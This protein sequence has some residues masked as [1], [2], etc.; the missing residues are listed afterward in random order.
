MFAVGLL[1]AYFI[2]RGEGVWRK[3]LFP[4]VQT[5]R[6]EE[7]EAANEPG[8]IMNRAFKRKLSFPKH[9]CEDLIKISRL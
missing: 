1:C 4:A 9:M 7:G 6:P 5:G 3:Q 8:G 2:V